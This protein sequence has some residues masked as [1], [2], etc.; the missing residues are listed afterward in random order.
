MEKLFAELSRLYLPASLKPDQEAALARTLA[1]G[2]PSA[3]NLVGSN[4]MV[5]TLVI[6]VGRGS[7]W[8]AVAALCTGL[9]TDLGW[10]APAIAVA[11]DS[12]YQVWL[13]LAAPIALAEAGEVL[14]ALRRKY[15]PDVPVSRLRCLPG[16]A[17]GEQS[18]PPVPAFHAESGR[19]SAFI[20]PGMGSMFK[21]ECGLDLAPNL[22]RQADMLA[23][24]ASIQATS[25]QQAIVSWQDEAVPVAD[26][27]QPEG[28]G[29]GG[30]LPTTI[31][32]G[33]GYSDPRSFLLAVM[34]D[35]TCSTRDRIEAARALLPY[36]G[37]P[38]P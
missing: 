28:A 24:L 10:P 23:G 27:A 3:L 22:E 19:W 38:L 14:Q 36:Y 1:G 26:G 25:L 17:A 9:Q 31:C 29:P 8:E 6:V 34:N 33:S 18:I 13:S 35:P 4:G 11:P 20:D 2:P 21:D 32:V 7:D 37:N 15:L 30:A 5:R 12:G 16:L